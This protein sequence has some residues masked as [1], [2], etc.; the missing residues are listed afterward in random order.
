MG[1]SKVSSHWPFPSSTLYRRTFTIQRIK[2]QDSQ[3]RYNVTLQFMHVTTVA[4]ETQQCVLY[5]LLSY[6]SLSVI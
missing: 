1:W 5:V 6:M 2:K 4:V 3:C